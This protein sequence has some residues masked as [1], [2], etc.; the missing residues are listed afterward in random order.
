MTKPTRTRTRPHAATSLVQSEVAT[1]TPIIPQRNEARETGR[2]R[3]LES[4]GRVGHHGERELHS[5]CF[6]AEHGTR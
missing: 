6:P 3:V 5:D 4:R 2:Q 1:Q